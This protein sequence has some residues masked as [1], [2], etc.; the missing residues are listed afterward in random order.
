MPLLPGEFINDQQVRVPDSAGNVGGPTDLATAL[1]NLGSIKVQVASK[2]I[3]TDDLTDAATNQVIAFDSALPSNAVVLRA[4]VEITTVFD[5][6]GTVDLDIG[7]NGGTSNSWLVN[8]DGK[9]AT[10]RVG[11]DTA[12]TFSDTGSGQTPE[13]DVKS[14]S[15]NVSTWTTGD[16]TCYVAYAVLS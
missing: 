11:G 1:S 10:G 3:T 2:Q 6:A 8:A 4:W 12:P 13:V 9:T 7:A 14:G 15:G 16:V 5:G